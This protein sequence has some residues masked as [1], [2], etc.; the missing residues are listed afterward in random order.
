MF[1][2]SFYKKKR[3]NYEE[4]KIPFADETSLFFAAVI[5]WVVSRFLACLMLFEICFMQGSCAS[6]IRIFDY[7]AWKMVR[8]RAE[9]P[10]RII[11]ILRYCASLSK[12]IIIGL[13][14]FKLTFAYLVFCFDD[15]RRFFA[16]MTFS[17]LLNY[18]G[19]YLGAHKH[20]HRKKQ[21]LRDVFVI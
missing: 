18:L 2:F 16:A 3:R 20:T 15:F 6:I 19:C 8:C 14:S 12:T 4:K 10:K 21:N 11:M 13:I 7:N 5:L 1:N 9:Q 17:I